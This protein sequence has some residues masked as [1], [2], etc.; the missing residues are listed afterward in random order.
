MSGKAFFGSILP[1]KSQSREEL[2]VN[3]EYPIAHLFQNS[4]TQL[5]RSK[6]LSAKACLLRQC[7]GVAKPPL[8]E[9]AR[10]TVHCD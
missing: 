3:R 9:R 10:V 6:G 8:Q 2:V 1:P 7:L 5:K 4:T